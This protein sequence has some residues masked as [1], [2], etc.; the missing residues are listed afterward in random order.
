MDVLC[1]DLGLVESPRWHDGRLWFSDWIAGQIIA[2]D[3]QGESEVMVS[4]ASL[5]S[6]TRP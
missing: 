3:D 1:R 6:P 5:P 2:V 4:H